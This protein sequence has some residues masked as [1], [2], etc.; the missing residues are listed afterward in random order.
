[1]AKSL[2]SQIET[3][4]QTVAALVA[5]QGLHIPTPKT[6][7][8]VGSRN[9]APRFA[10][11]AKSSKSSEVEDVEVR[12]PSADINQGR[13]KLPARMFGDRSFIKVDGVKY[14]PLDSDAGRSKPIYPTVFDAEEGQIVTFT[15]VGKGQW[16]SSVSG[17]KAKGKAKGQATARTSTKATR[18]PKAKA[19]AEKQVGRAVKVSPKKSDL[20]NEAA[21]KF[22]MA[23]RKNAKAGYENENIL[24]TGTFVDD[25]R[26]YLTSREN[27]QAKRIWKRRAGMTLS[28]WVTLLG[29]VVYDDPDF[30]AQNAR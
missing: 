16:E 30:E 6:T 10:S 25:P 9:E 19:K 27:A 5:A 26:Q 3:L 24:E 22:G 15:Y 13:M 2:A 4:S 7:A 17:R 28:D 20:V 21:E 12:V 11:K 14:E 1:M 23:A 18:S 29:Q 8:K